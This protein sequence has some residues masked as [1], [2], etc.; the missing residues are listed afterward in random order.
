MSLWK[1]KHYIIHLQIFINS[2]FVSSCFLLLAMGA[3]L[4]AWPLMASYSLTHLPNVLVVGF[5]CI[6]WI[7][8]MPWTWFLGLFHPLITAPFIVYVCNSLIDWYTT[9][10]LLSMFWLFSTKKN[11]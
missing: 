3:W 8:I 4:V 2:T 11:S 6:K 1:T 10:P 5:L 7:F 9:P